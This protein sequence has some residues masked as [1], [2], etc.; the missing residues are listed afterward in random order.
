VFQNSTVLLDG[1]KSYDPNPGG[2]IV[3]YQWTQLPTNAGVPVTLIG[4]NTATPYFIA[5]KLPSDNT[6]L[7]FSLKVMDNH[8]GISANPAVVYVMV[9]HAPTTTTTTTPTV[10]H[11]PNMSSGGII[12]SQ[13][14]QQ[15]L[16]KASIPGQP[17]SAGTVLAV[18]HVPNMSSG[19]II[20]SQQQQQLLPKASIPGQPSIP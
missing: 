12:T 7:A 18:P 11:V 1:R 20:T 19:G 15:L 14:Q 6:L 9:K 10:P 17:P 5:P 13:Q 4:G 2:S 8:V 16:P 3:A